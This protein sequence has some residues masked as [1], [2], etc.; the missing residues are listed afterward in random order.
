MST[1]QQT[2]DVAHPA[3]K[4][5]TAWGMVGITSWADF[6]SALAAAYTIILITEWLWKKCLRPFAEDRGWVKRK[7]RRR[8]DRDA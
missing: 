6:A 5:V 4:I 2:A 7:L 1:T 3:V 8:E